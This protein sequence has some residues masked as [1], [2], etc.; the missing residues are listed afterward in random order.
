MR[1]FRTGAKPTALHLALAM[2]GL[3]GMVAAS[4]LAHAQVAV[5]AGALAA[6]TPAK[7]AVKPMPK[8]AIKPVPQADASPL[9]SVV[10]PARAPVTGKVELAPQVNLSEGKSTL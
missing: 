3:I 10:M 2:T 7:P 6:T 9:K 8:P 1:T 4:T 5:E